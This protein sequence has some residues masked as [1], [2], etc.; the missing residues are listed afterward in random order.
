MNLETPLIISSLLVEHIVDK[1]LLLFF[2]PTSQFSQDEIMNYKIHKLSLSSNL[3]IKFFP[4]FIT[5]S[6]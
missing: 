2:L 5:S 6:H 1:P 3:G 4:S